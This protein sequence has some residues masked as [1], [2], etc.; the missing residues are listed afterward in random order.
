MRDMQAHAQP[1]LPFDWEAYTAWTRRLRQDRVEEYL[2][3]LVAAK[4]LVPPSGEGK[5]P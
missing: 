4:L 3:G 5:H 2:L 1:F